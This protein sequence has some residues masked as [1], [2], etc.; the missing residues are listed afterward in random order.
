MRN[1]FS[2]TGVLVDAS[3][4][5]ELEAKGAER[6]NFEPEKKGNRA[7]VGKRTCWSGCDSRTLVQESR[8]LCRGKKR[9]IQ[10]AR[11]MNQSVPSLGRFLADVCSFVS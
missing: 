1:T 11:H 7:S 4:A 5:G 10:N 8:G 6:E 3:V 2:P 9:K